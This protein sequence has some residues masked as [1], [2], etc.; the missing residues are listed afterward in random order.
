MQILSCGYID[1]D[2]VY[3]FLYNAGVLKTSRADLE[4]GNAAEVDNAVFDSID[5]TNVDTVWLAVL[6][7][8]LKRGRCIFDNTWKGMVTYRKD[9]GHKAVADLIIRLGYELSE[10]EEQLLNGTHKL[11]DR[12]EEDESK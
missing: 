11:F 8:V 6:L 3:D 7:I 5:M 2:D 4:E 12:E 9:T 10:E 1:M